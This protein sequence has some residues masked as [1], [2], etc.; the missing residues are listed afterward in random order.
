MSD[1]CGGCR[2]DPTEAGRGGR[3]PLHR[4]LLGLPRPHRDRLA[5]N[6]RMRAAAAAASTGSPTS[7]RW[8]SRSRSAER[9][10]RSQAT[11]PPAGGDAHS[12]PDDRQR[13]A[14]REPVG[15]GGHQA[16]DRPAEPGHLGPHRDAVLRVAEQRRA[17]RRGGQPGRPARCSSRRISAC[18]AVSGRPPRPLAGRPRGA[19]AAPVRSSRPRSGPGPVRADQ[20]A[21]RRPAPAGTARGRGRRAAA[22]PAAPRSGRAPRCRTVCATQPWSST[23]SSGP[24]TAASTRRGRLPQPLEPLLVVPPQ[25]GLG[26]PDGG[27]DERDDRRVQGHRRPADVDDAEQLAGA[28]VVDRRGRAVPG[29][30]VGLE[31]LGGEQLH[32][33]RLGQRGADRVG[34]DLVLGPLGALREAERV[35]ARPRPGR[36]PRAR[37]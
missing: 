11:T 15:I 21:A 5:G 27:L 13:D 4:G 6:H 33:A 12:R 19:P 36:R 23:S 17:E 7:T 2:Y 22:R 3:L 10:R 26:Q 29:V 31:V 25:L 16:T 18:R 14:V 9:R 37:G 1:Y 32:R 35:G 30:L 24:C 8:S 34:A 20:P 28:R